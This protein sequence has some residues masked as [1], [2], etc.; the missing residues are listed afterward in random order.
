MSVDDDG[1]GWTSFALADPTRFHAFLAPL[2]FRAEGERTARVRMTPRQ[3]HSNMR[4]A[5][6]GG[7]TLAFIDMALFVASRSF[8]LTTPGT[9]VTLDLS[10][11]FITE[12]RLDQ[13]LDAVVELLRET[14]RLLFMRG[15][16][17]QDQGTV[18]SFAGTIRKPSPKR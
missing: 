18:A 11:Q 5:V 12:A 10:T 16:V 6:H 9:A 8:G 4:D 3:D 7:A 15:L 2:R 1:E 17:V 13:P 14:G